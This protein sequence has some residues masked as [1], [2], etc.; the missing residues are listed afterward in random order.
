VRSFEVD[1]IPALSTPFAQ[2]KRLVKL[3]EKWMPVL[4]A[5]WEVSS[6]QKDAFTKGNIKKEF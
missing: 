3:A 6:R 2:H 5:T 4:V 1:F